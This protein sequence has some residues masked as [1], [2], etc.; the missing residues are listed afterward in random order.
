[1]PTWTS[2]SRSWATSG[3]LIITLGKGMYYR[4]TVAKVSPGNGKENWW[5]GATVANAGRAGGHSH[6][7]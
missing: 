6:L 4:E 1:M 2:T 3:S 7:P 5:A